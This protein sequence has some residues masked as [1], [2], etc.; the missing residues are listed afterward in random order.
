[1]SMADQDF[2][3]KHGTNTNKCIHKV[4]YLNPPPGGELLGLCV[5]NPFFNKLV[6]YQTVTC[7]GRMGG[8]IP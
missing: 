4:I 5:A 7:H 1:M 3:S 6:Q 2:F 8:M